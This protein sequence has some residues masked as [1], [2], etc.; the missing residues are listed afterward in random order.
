M[1]ITREELF[2]WALETYGTQPDY[3]WGDE[4]A[5]LRHSGNNKW[6]AAVLEVSRNKLGLDGDGRVCVV[7]VKCDPILIGALRAQEGYHPAYHMNKDLWITMRL[8]GSVPAEEIQRLVGFSYELVQ[9]KKKK[10]K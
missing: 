9:P 4:N 5:V 2:A 6:Y 1:A 3:P 7:N 10:R 8:D